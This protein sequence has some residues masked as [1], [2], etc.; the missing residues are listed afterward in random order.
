MRRVA[1]KAVPLESWE[2]DPDHQNQSSEAN[3]CLHVW[4]TLPFAGIKNLATFGISDDYK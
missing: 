4:Q 2:S 3:T 1:A